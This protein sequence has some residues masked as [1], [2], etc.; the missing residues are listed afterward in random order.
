MNNKFRNTVL[1]KNKQKTGTTFRCPF[2]AYFYSQLHEQYEKLITGNNR[3]IKT[4]QR[5]NYR[6]IRD[7]IVDILILITFGYLNTV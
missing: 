7:V 1:H 5:R 2:F 3:E 6:T 4:I